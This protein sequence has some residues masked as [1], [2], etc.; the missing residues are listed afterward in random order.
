MRPCRPTWLR[1][2]SRHCIAQKRVRLCGFVRGAYAQAGLTC[3]RL[4]PPLAEEPRKLWCQLLPKLYIPEETDDAKVHALLF[5]IEELKKVILAQG[6][7]T[8]GMLTLL[9]EQNRPIGDT[10]SR[11]AFNRFAT[12]LHKAF[13]ERLENLDEE[14]R[15]VVENSDEVKALRGWVRKVEREEEGE[16]GDDDDDEEEAGDDDD[17]EDTDEDDG[18][19]EEEEEGT[20]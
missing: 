2:C 6:N 11:N 5:F 16:S 12:S 4:P 7:A 10:V 13:D 15:A 9:T 1:R 17:A 3:L 14:A 19:E 20:E 8:E 18:E